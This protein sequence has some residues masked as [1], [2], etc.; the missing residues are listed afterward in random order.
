LLHGGGGLYK[1]VLYHAVAILN[2]ERNYADDL[3]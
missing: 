1:L 3:W 2:K